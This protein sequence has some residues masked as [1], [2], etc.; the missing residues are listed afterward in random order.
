VALSD[1]QKAMLRLLA[2]RGEQGYDDIAALMGLSV[3]EVRGRV[4]EALAQLEE[5]G[6]PAPAIP[7][8]PEGPAPAQRPKSGPP[9][10]PVPPPEPTTPPPPEPAQGSEA[11]PKPSASPPPPSRRPKISLPSE[12][13]PRAAI[14]AGIGVLV[15]VIVVLVLS[16]G[17]GSSNSTTTT[18]TTAAE[19]AEEAA[20]TAAKGKEVTKAVLSAV[21]GSE[22]AGVALF[23]RVKNSLALQVAAEGLGP[24]GRGESYTV[25]LAQSPQKMLPL[26]STRVGKDGRIAAQVQVPTEVLAYLANETFGEITVTRTSDTALKASLKKATSE[27]NAPAYT[28]TEVLRGT[29]TGPIVGAAKRSQGE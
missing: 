18:S 6:I 22:A 19:S 14:A 24:T 27:K 8:S 21:D 9:S 12:R 4:G 11:S 10:V 17:G 1:D 20:S 28:G 2:Q 5:E 25:W 23:G 3:E 13:G 29:V 16:S 7:A 26:A 15:L